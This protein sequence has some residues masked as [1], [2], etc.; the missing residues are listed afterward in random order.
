MIPISIGLPPS[1]RLEPVSTGR[2]HRTSSGL[3][4]RLWRLSLNRTGARAAVRGLSVLDSARRA[5]ALSRPPSP[6]TG[7]PHQ[8]RAKIPA[9]RVPANRMA[10]GAVRAPSPATT[11]GRPPLAGHGPDRPATH[12]TP[13]RRGPVSPHP[14]A[15]HTSDSPKASRRAHR[16]H[17]SAAVVCASA[18]TAPLKGLRLR[19]QSERCGTGG[20][21]GAG[22]EGS[23]EVVKDVNDG[24]RR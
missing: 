7:H 4:R 12:P 3:I 22:T 11:G 23:S 21:T 6:R 14:V 19:P 17:N 15:R 5:R 24:S 10:E 18:R 1:V 8:G 20:V 9:Q 16:G 13:A 2:A